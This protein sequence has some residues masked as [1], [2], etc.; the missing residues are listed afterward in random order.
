MRSRITHAVL[1]IVLTSNHEGLTTTTEKD[2]NDN[3]H[4]VRVQDCS[5]WNTVASHNGHSY[6]FAPEAVDYYIKHMTKGM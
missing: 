3:N 4:T 2:G 6:Q 5:P 1:L